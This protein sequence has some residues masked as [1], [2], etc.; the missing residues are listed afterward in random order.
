MIREVSA[1]DPSELTWFKSSYS[2]SGVGNDCTEVAAAPGHRPRPGFQKTKST[3]PPPLR[4]SR[5]AGNRM[6][7]RGSPASCLPNCRG[8]EREEGR[9]S[10]R[11]RLCFLGGQAVDRDRQ[12]RAG[13]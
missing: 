9:T 2:S 12:S 13:R 7:G 4:G 10:H 3:A 11:C 5:L 8:L 6:P 1:G